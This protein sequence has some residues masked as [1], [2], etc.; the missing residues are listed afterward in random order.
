MG[1][2]QLLLSSGVVNFTEAQGRSKH[3]TENA[4]GVAG[5]QVTIGVSVFLPLI[6][7]AVSCI[8]FVVVSIPNPNPNT[9]VEL[10]NKGTL[11]NQSLTLLNAVSS[12]N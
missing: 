1:F 9:Q 3:T 5:V 7:S 11:T 8:S 12:I 4:V 6:Y 2:K 10:D